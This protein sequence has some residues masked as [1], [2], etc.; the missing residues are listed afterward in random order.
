MGNRFECKNVCEDRE[1]LKYKIT[2]RK[3]FGFRIY[4]VCFSEDVQ[5]ESGEFGGYFN[6]KDDAKKCFRDY[7]DG[8]ERTVE[9]GEM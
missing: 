8:L 7:A 6:T 4:V 1:T 3:G 5:I 9:E 2:E